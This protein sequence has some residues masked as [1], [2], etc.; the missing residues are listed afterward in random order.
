MG[1]TSSCSSK[2]HSTL[3]R[4]C[5]DPVRSFRTS[6]EAQCDREIVMEVVQQDWGALRYASAALRGDR[7]IVMEAVQQNGHA[8][9]YASAELKGDREFMME[10]IKKNWRALKYASPEVQGDREIVMEA[11]KQNEFVGFPM[12]LRPTC[13]YYML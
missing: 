10:A 8:L 1:I 9:N 12:P 7:E 11:G 6:A 3:R 2:H 5:K 4:S 13:E